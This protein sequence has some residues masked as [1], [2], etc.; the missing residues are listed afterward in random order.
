MKNTDSFGLEY[1]LR[2]VMSVGSFF[3]PQIARVS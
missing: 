3:S 1:A 2:T